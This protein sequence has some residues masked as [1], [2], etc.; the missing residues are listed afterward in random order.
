MTNSWRA[1]ARMARDRLVN[2]NPADLA[3]VLGVSS[4]VLTL[5]CEYILTRCLAL[6]F[7]HSLLGAPS[8]IQSGSCRMLQPFYHSEFNL[9]RKFANLALR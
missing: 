1:L 8:P 2:S 4:L 7:A 6:V 5:A 9:A 3:L